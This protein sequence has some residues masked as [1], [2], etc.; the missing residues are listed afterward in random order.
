MSD[1]LVVVIEEMAKD[2]ESIRLLAIIVCACL[3]SI[4]GAIHLRFWRD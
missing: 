4:T 3:A 2:V 1:S